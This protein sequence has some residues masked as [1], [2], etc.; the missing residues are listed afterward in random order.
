VK[1]TDRLFDIRGASAAA[2]AKRL[3]AESERR[4]KAEQ[5]RLAR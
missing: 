1:T 2:E 3:L 5:R 4:Q